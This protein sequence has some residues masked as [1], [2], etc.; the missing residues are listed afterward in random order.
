MLQVHVRLG[1]LTL[2]PRL[3]GLVLLVEVCH[4]CA[5]RSSPSGFDLDGDTTTLVHTWDQIL[6]DIHVR[7]GVDVGGR[8]GL[9]DEAQAGQTV[10]AINVHGAGTANTLSARSERHTTTFQ[11]TV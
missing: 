1:I 6:D 9:V 3:D 8:R 10:G 4:V 2:Q 11:Y 7:Q 5:K